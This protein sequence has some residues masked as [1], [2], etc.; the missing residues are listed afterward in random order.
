M[1]ISKRQL[2]RIIREQAEDPFAM[3]MRVAT[4][5]L[6]YPPVLDE[7]MDGSIT[8]VA[9]EQ[10]DDDNPAFGMFLSRFPD[11]EWVDFDEFST[12]VMQ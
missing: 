1:K 9:S 6:G 11:G 7:E 10:V 4:E 5:I 12:G 3:V 8:V 2:R